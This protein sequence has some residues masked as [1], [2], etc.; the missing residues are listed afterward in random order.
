MASSDN[1]I[2][3]NVMNEGS[4]YGLYF[5]TGASNNLYRANAARSAGVWRPLW[6]LGTNNLSAGDN[7]LP[8]RR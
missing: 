7:Y 2:E 3:A 5:D 4:D 1:V 8:D 6:D